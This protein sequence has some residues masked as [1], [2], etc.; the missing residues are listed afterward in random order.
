MN[1]MGREELDEQLEQLALI[2]QQHPPLTPKRQLALGQ[3]VGMI[4][5]SN[6][7]CHPHRGKFTHRYEEIYEEARQDL[8]FYV[9]QNIDKYNPERG[10]VMAWCNVLLERRF[11]REAIPKVLGKPDIQ[12]MTLSDLDNFALPEE[13]PS[14]TEVIQECIA[15]DPE[16]LFKNSY[17]E[18]HPQANFQILTL[19]RLAGK[20]WKD[21][22]ESFGIKLPTISS[23]Y[24]RCLNRFASYLKE[25]CSRNL[26]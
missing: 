21:I 25:Y 18:N 12:K 19:Q 5:T 9:C 8:M 2:S 26:T 6:R 11:F 17:I 3:L 1:Q 20:S 14:L 7:L 10:G 15:L 13:S 4:L 24:Y 23:F 22:S 16:N